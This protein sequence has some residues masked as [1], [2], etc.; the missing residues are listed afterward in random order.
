MMGEHLRALLSPLGVYD[1]DGD[2]VS[3]AMVDALGDALDPVRQAISDGLR[4]AFVQTAG[5]DALTQW[6]RMAPPHGG[7]TARQRRE[8][9]A[10][11][12]GQ[13][14]VACSKARL[15]AGLAACGV[16]A[17]LEVNGNTV[18]VY[19]TQ[20]P[21]AAALARSLLPAHMDIEWAQE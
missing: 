4:D 16:Q 11:L 3:G 12:L 17:T 21:E 10:F 13:E 1:L 15:E 19:G 2:S 18:T 20:T 14:D 6:E 9:V 7:G 5:D 8:A